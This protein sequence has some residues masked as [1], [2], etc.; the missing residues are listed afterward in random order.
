MYRLKK[1][2][3]ISKM[4]ENN[5]RN[6]THAMTEL[7]RLADEL[8]LP[9][10]VK[11]RA[12]IIYRLALK[13]DLIKGRTIAGFVA[14]S[15]YASCRESG[16]PRTLKDVTD[17]STEKFKDISRTYRFLIRKLH[18]KMPVDHPMKYVPRV[19]SEIETSRETERHTIKLLH[20][21]KRRKILNGKDPMGMV[22]AALYMVSKENG[23]RITQ[24][25]I[26]SAADTTEVTL[27]NRLKDIEEITNFN[28]QNINQINANL[29]Y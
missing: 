21:A 16:V 12:A 20:E 23:E 27:R 24:K 11:E 4:D 10:D 1:H 18:L 5:I 13:K 25:D 19:A 29:R 6:L 2:D 9:D 22:A 14:A 17:V 28:H 15:V 26:A 3:I 8:H 7:S